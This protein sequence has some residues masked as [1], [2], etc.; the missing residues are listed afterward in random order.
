MEFK[1]INLQEELVALHVE[2]NAANSL[3]QA[4]KVHGSPY[5]LAARMTKLE[6]SLQDAYE[7]YKD[8]SNSAEEKAL[9]VE[10]Y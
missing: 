8:T 4:A 7:W 2:V 10:K 1:C 5:T 6:G 3:Q 9:Q